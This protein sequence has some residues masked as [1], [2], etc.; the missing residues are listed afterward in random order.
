[1]VDPRH[2]TTA[3]K[4][5]RDMGIPVVAIMSSDCDVRDI[6]KPVFVNDAQRASVSLALDEL[7]EGYREGADAR[8]ASARL[9]EAVSERSEDNSPVSVPRP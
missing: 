4:E 6:I 8:D 7:V 1:V 5:A 9:T 2:E 3:V